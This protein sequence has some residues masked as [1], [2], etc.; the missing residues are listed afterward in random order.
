MRASY[1]SQE[2]SEFSSDRNMNELANQFCG[3][4]QSS[5]QAGPRIKDETEM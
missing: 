5:A 3:A 1:S 4:E 2:D